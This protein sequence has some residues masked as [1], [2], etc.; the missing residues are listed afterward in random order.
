[1]PIR[2]GVSLAK[3]NSIKRQNGNLL[4]AWVVGNPFVNSTNIKKIFVTDN[5]T[6]ATIFNELNFTQGTTAG[7]SDGVSIFNP[8]FATF[9]AYFFRSD[10]QKWRLSL[11]R[12]GPDQND[13]VIPNKSIVR[14]QKILAGSSTITLKG[15]ARV[16]VYQ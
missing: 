3:N 2:V 8:N 1:M 6:I 7:S 5:N 4:Q 13:V 16:G 14:F 10:V 9:T 15:T 12:T 11:N